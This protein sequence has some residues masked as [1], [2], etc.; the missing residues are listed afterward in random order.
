MGKVWIALLALVAAT[1]YGD[2]SASQRRLETALQQARSLPASE[3]RYAEEGRLLYW[4][5]QYTDDKTAKKKLVETG[6]ALMENIQAEVSNDN[7]RLVTWIA[8]KGELAM[9]KNKLVALTYLRPIEK[10]ALRL[11]ANDPKYGHYAADR[12]LGRIYHLAPGFIS[13]GSN[14]KAR[15]HFQMAIE[16]DGTY[17]ENL[18]FYAEFLSNTGEPQRAQELAAAALKSPLLAQYPMERDSWELMGK[19]LLSA[20]ASE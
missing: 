13:I 19:R 10:A 9:L 17:P 14:S 20:G 16:G 11:K 7:D 18:L 2:R 1:S 12:I 15:T 6:M 3:A 8:L 4:L 5:A